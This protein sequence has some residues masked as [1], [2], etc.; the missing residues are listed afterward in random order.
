MYPSA[1]PP[2]YQERIFDSATRPDDEVAYP[3][4]TQ[5]GQ[6]EGYVYLIKFELKNAYKIGRSIDPNNR[7]REFIVDMPVELELIHAFPA[8]DYFDAES[9]LQAIC[10]DNGWHLTGEWFDLPDTAVRVIS[11]IEKYENRQFR[12]RHYTNE[13]AT[14]LRDYHGA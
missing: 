2:D 7:L 9:E 3:R 5:A 1:L 6:R 12:N 13:V 14:I 4:M 10:K 11:R 8:S